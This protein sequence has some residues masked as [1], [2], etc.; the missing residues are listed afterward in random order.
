MNARWIFSLAAGTAV[1]LCG[2][3]LATAAAPNIGQNRSPM[4][5]SAK[6]IQGST[7]IGVTVLDSQGAKTRPDQRGLSRLSDRQGDFLGSRRGGDGLG[8]PG[9]VHR[10]ASD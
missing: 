2:A 4:Q 10:G 9:D 8:P 5:G 7:L 6:S 1:L 3:L